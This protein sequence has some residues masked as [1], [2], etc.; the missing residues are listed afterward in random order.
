MSPEN[1]KIFL[2]I[3]AGHTMI[4]VAE[5]LNLILGVICLYFTIKL[6][7]RIW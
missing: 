7:W 5:V 1:F 2:L 3:E 4:F 6:I